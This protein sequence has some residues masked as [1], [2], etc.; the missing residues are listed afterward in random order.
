MCIRRSLNHILLIVKNVMCILL[1]VTFANN[2]IVYGNDIVHSCLGVPNFFNPP[3]KIEKIESDGTV[4]Y[5]VHYQDFDRKVPGYVFLWYVIADACVLGLNG[6][7]L[8][9]L[10]GETVA[11]KFTKEDLR[12]FDWENIA[13]KNGDL[14][15][16]CFENTDVYR[17][18]QRFS[19]KDAVLKIKMHKKKTI[20]VFIEKRF[21]ARSQEEDED[22]KYRMLAKKLLRKSQ[23]KIDVCATAGHDIE[24][25][26]KWG[27]LNK[28]ILKSPL[29]ERFGKM[30]LTIPVTSEDDVSFSY[31]QHLQRASKV[32]N[33]IAE[34]WK[35]KYGTDQDI[36][37]VKFVKG[38]MLFFLISYQI[39][40]IPTSVP[41]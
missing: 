5:E 12:P 26:E 17:F 28:V 3:C 37:I 20:G 13:Y 1:I 22:T 24:A 19:S 27:E 11:K 33:M 10:I 4:R 7:E 29:C 14:L 15:L 21:V 34:K 6:E 32:A 8:K 36:G 16:P 31:E 23:E 30:G 18:T 38:K 2:T 25:L 9:D 39:G 41:S 35:E 40:L